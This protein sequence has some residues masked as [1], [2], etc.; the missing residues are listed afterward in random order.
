MIKRRNNDQLIVFKKDPSKISAIR[1][2]MAATIEQPRWDLCRR[3]IIKVRAGTPS[4]GFANKHSL[5][6]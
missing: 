4:G 6:T 3:L 5:I 1:A 2:Y